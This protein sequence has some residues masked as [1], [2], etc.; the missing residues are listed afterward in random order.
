MSPRAAVKVVC[1]T[2]MPGCGKEEFL[3]V[4]VARGFTV[5]RMGDVV[6]DEA[7]NRGLPLTDAAVGSLAHEE[8]QRHG[9]GVWAERTLPRL[10]GD[11]VLIEGLRGGAEVEVFRERFGERL[12]VVAIHAAPRLR[13]E[14]VSK[15]GRSDDIRSWEGFV[16]RDRRELGWGLG[17][18]I[19]QADF[20][21]VNEGDLPAFRAA[22]SSVLDAVEGS[23]DG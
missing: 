18:V 14:R 11:R 6:R 7:R 2:G 3:S 23:P 21:I 17:D 9:S 15:R 19:A 16:T 8:R 10:A 4:S 22:A 5:V 13:F 20:M 1:V 12:A